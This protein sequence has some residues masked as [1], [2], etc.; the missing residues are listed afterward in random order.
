ML[1]AFNDS[2]IGHLWL[3]DEDA[4]WQATHRSKA[5][6]H[7][8]RA[9][10]HM[11]ALQHSALIPRQAA[12]ALTGALR[13]ILG[14]MNVPV[15]LQAWL[16]MIDVQQHSLLGEH[17]QA[18][19]LIRSR[20]LNVPPSQ[21]VDAW[22]CAASG[23]FHDA[24]LRLSPPRPVGGN[25]FKGDR[26][27]LMAQHLEPVRDIL[28]GL[29]DHRQ[30]CSPKMQAQL[31][32]ISVVLDSLRGAKADRSAW[33]QLAADISSSQPTMAQ[34]YGQLASA[35]VFLA[36][37]QTSRAELA[38]EAAMVS[39]RKLGWGMGDW[40]ASHEL[41]CLRHGADSHDAR[42]QRLASV[43]Q[44]VC[45]EVDEGA[46][47]APLSVPSRRERVQK[48]REFIVANLGQRI[49]VEAV[50]SHCAVSSRTLSHDFSQEMGKSPLDYINEQKVRHAEVLIGLGKSLREVAT[51]VGFD[52]VLG[53][54]KAYARVRGA[55]PP[56]DGSGMS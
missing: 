23:A 37:G 40:F 10:R 15:E 2:L 53:F 35:W 34:A 1:N 28:A 12:H 17:E 52:S 36:E 25:P 47:G 48:A 49:S 41:D 22:A 42:L 27:E 8:F 55:P 4:H 43:R 13:A 33:L 19:A 32:R 45:A 5:G 39:A 46:A 6:H 38:L 20:L 51:A 50:A 30:L 31:L 24:W 3:F 26:V 54:V 44:K 29:G 21:A 18:Q 56:P 14:G 9:I 16:T 11:W 7:A